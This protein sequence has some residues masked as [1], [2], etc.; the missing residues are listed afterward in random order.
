[1]FFY[2]SLLC[3]TKHNRSV[4]RYNK[5]HPIVLSG[6][7][8]LIAFHTEI[9]VLAPTGKP[10]M[11][12]ICFTYLGFVSKSGGPKRSK[13]NLPVSEQHP[14]YTVNNKKYSNPEYWGKIPGIFKLFHRYSKME[15]NQN[16]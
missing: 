12:L 16:I 10:V 2:W 9:N 13:Q 15:N 8:L 4:W 3:S 5:S 1:M 11:L 7:K 14:L 6:N